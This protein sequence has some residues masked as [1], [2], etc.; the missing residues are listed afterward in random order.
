[1][2]SKLYLG[3]EIR[4][5]NGWGNLNLKIIG[6]KRQQSRTKISVKYMQYKSIILAKLLWLTPATLATQEAEIRGIV[7][8]S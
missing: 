1:M 8:Q 4:I 6:G 3:K 2:Y 7:V 5:R